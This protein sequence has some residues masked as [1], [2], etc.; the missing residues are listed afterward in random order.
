MVHAT[1]A[2]HATHATL[3]VIF[4]AFPALCPFAP[5]RPRGE[6]QAVPCGARSDIWL[7]AASTSQPPP[8]DIGSV[9]KFITGTCLHAKFKTVLI[10]A[11]TSIYSAR[12][13]TPAHPHPDAFTPAS[14]STRPRCGRA[15]VYPCL[16]P[17]PRTRGGIRVLKITVKSDLET[18]NA[19]DTHSLAL[20]K[21][22]R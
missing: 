1:L 4:Q 17:C 10:S 18:S 14:T 21:S 2:A 9:R 3:G 22:T 13:E 19:N 16:H 8:V 11:D 15:P 20:L 7:L 6:M 12:K 5:R